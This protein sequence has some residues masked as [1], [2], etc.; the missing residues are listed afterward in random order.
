MEKE[1]IPHEYALTLK[2]LEF[3]ELCVGM[4][5]EV[6]DLYIHCE[7]DNWNINIDICSAPTYQQAFRWFREEYSMQVNITT[8]VGQEQYDAEI[9]LDK[10]LNSLSIRKQE[11][12]S[13]I[14]FFKSYEEAELA[15]LRKLIEICQKQK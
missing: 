12:D 13:W 1:F 2:E 4:F 3:E 15:C 11:D 8:F 7:F 9:I 14:E 6:G 5:D 10:E